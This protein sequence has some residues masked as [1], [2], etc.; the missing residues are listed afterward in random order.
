MILVTGATGM[1]GAH[2][3]LKLLEKGQRV[4]ALIRSRERIAETKRIFGFY[5]SDPDALLSKVEWVTGDVLDILSL[6]KALDGVEYVY[7]AGGLVSF[8]AADRGQLLKVN[9]EGTANLVNCCLEKKVKKLAHVSSIAV[10]GTC[11]KRKFPGR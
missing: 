6:E 11:R 3:L 9:G 4:R 8:D 10:F 2:L 1:V 5:H 7:H